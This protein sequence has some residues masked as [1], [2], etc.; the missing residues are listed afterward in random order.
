MDLNIIIQSAFLILYVAL[1]FI[2]LPKAKNCKDIRYLLVVKYGLAIVLTLHVPYLIITLLKLKC[3]IPDSVQMA[4]CVL[5]ITCAIF[6][7]FKANKKIKS[8]QQ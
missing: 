4:V 5:S 7:I 3:L 1:F 8:A 2:F 6:L